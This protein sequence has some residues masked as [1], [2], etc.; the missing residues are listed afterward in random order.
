MGRIVINGVYIIKAGG[1]CFSH[2][3]DGNVKT[4]DVDLMTP[5]ISALDSFTNESFNGKIKGL[6]L[7]DDAGV[8]RNVYFRDMKV[9]NSSYKIVVITSGRVRNQKEIDSKMVQF[10]WAMQEKRWFEYLDRGSTPPSV[11]EAIKEKIKT[12]FEIA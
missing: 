1:I 2:I 12:L 7:E 6:T 4:N 3:D 9:F 10:K 5:F 8:E 11:Q